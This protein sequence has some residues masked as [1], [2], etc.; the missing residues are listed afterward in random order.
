[1]IIIITYE[2]IISLFPLDGKYFFLLTN[3]FF[4]ININKKRGAI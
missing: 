3:C 2:T 1:M 4:G